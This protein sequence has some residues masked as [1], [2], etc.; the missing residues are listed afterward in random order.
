MSYITVYTIN[1]NGDVDNFGEAQNA[2]ACAPYIWR[3]LSEKYGFGNTFLDAEPPVWRKFIDPT[4]PIADR[5]VLGFTFDSPWIRREN[6]P[7]L[8][9]ALESFWREHHSRRESDG[10]TIA[11]VD[12][13]PRVV[14]LLKRAF[15]ADCRGVCF[16]QTSVSDR[17]WQ[18]RQFCDKCGHDLD[19]IRPFN[20]DRDRTNAID[21]E[22]W[23]L[24][25]ALEKR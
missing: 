17:I 21:A 11:V 25:D 16:Q 13:I 8:T 3:V 4:V 6:I 23:E 22:P 9:E 15:D 1:H 18:I 14:E 19:D 12:T 5:I 2:M 20:F 10:K 7:R 24:F